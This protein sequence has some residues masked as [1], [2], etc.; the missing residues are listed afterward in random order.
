MATPRAAPPSRETQ[1]RQ[2]HSQMRSCRRT[3]PHLHA[4]GSAEQQA[5][6]KPAPFLPSLTRQVLAPP[7]SGRM[8]E[9]AEFKEF[10]SQPGAMDRIFARIAPQ[11]GICS[12]TPRCLRL[13]RMRSM[14]AMHRRTLLSSKPGILW[15]PATTSPRHAHTQ[16]SA[17]LPGVCRSL[18]VPTSRR[19]SPACCLVA[20]ASAC[21]TAPTAAATLMCCCW[22]SLGPFQGSQPCAQPAL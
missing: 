14:S 1:G 12:C 19:P 9:E 20:L 5:N 21:L 16:P 17:S 8:E 6:P 3:W 4:A 13:L 11:V 7:R 10:A 18:A 22:V 2:W 15:R